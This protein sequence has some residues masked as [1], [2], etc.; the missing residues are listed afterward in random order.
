M[1]DIFDLGVL[2]GYKGDVEITSTG[3]GEGCIMGGGEEREGVVVVGG[4]GVSDEC[5]FVDFEGGSIGGSVGY[6]GR[7]IEETEVFESTRD[8]NAGG[9]P[10]EV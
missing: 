2:V 4:D 1:V 8:A 9:G 5:C 6:K 7:N 3:P 10:G